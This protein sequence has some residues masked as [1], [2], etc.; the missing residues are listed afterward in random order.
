MPQIFA[1]LWQEAVGEMADVTMLAYSYRSVQWH[2]DEY[3]AIRF[4][5]LYG[6]YD[7]CVIQQCAHPFPGYEET[8]EG[9]QTILRLCRETHTTPYL[10]MPWAEKRYPERQKNITD[11]LHR[12]AREEQM[13]PLPIGEVWKTVQEQHPEIELY[14]QDGEHA[15]P[16]GDYLIALVLCLILSGRRNLRFSNQ[17]RDF[18]RDGGI[19]FA[20]PKVIEMAELLPTILPPAAASAIQD[21]VLQ[22]ICDDSL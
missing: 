14:W 17:T 3:F 22:I 4:N 6:N 19:D 12:I 9:L 20:K 21:A 8:R 13:I 2:S 18:I 7:G 5:L 11:T 10:F 15:S 16:F 1:D